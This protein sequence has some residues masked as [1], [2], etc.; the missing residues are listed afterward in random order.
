[1]AQTQYNRFSAIYVPISEIYKYEYRKGV[2]QFDP[3]YLDAGCMK[4]SRVA[5]TGVVVGNKTENGS[6]AITIDD[7]SSTIE[8]REYVDPSKEGPILLNELDVGNLIKV[9]GKVKEFGG[10]R[11]V[12]AEI[13]KKTTAD[14]LKFS[15]VKARITE[16]DLKIK[17]KGK[18]VAQAQSQTQQ[19]QP[20]SSTTQPQQAENAEEEQIMDAPLER[21]VNKAEIICKIIEEEDKGTGVLIKD[22]VEKSNMDDCEKII[23]NLLE[24]GDIFM[25]QPGKVKVLN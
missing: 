22:I 13:V 25:V 11:Y 23:N 17:N 14:W 6:P 18:P 4:I 5:L 2:A 10:Q 21:I 19:A 1:M 9:I 8:V 20:T 24:N 7:K 16:L 3:N 12:Q 15:Q